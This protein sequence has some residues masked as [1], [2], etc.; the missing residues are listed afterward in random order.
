MWLNGGNNRLFYVGTLYPMYTLTMYEA[1]AIL[2][3]KI[4]AKTVEI[5]TV[6]EMRED[7]L[8]WIKK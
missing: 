1:E 7:V 5:P 3:S 6:E 2:V 4:M 8:K